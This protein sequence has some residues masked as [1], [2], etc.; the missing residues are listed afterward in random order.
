MQVS[1]NASSIECSVVSKNSLKKKLICASSELHAGVLAAGQS[2]SELQKRISC[3]RGHQKLDIWL[4]PAP[5]SKEK[6]TGPGIDSL[7]IHHIFQSKF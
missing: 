7:V 5:S 3:H 2:R 1:K 4:D 6:L